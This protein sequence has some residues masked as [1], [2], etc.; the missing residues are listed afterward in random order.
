MPYGAEIGLAFDLRGGGGDAEE[1][2]KGLADPADIP[3]PKAARFLG[4]LSVASSDRS[5][6]S[7]SVLSPAVPRFKAPM[8]EIDRVAPR[9]V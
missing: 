4:W 1:S 6:I 3:S 5:F 7:T 9:L 8:P 2:R